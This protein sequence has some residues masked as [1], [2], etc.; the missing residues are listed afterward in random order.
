MDL[1][2]RATAQLVAPFPE[3]VRQGLM[4]GF[5]DRERYHAALLQFHAKH[6]CTLKPPPEEYIRA[7]DAVFGKDGDP[8][9]GI[10]MFSGPL[11]DWSII[12][13]LHEI[14]VPVLVIN[15]RDDIA[16]D[17]VCEPFFHHIPRVKWVTFEKSSHTPMWEER[18]RFVHIV[19]DFLDYEP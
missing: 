11:R 4:V 1:W 14:R 3:E 18:E 8:T 5:A 15:G 16:Q 10:A 12:D 19:G 17:F 2:N 13:R 6:G 9:V 7:L